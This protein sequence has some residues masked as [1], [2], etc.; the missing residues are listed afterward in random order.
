MGLKVFAMKEFLTSHIMI[1]GGL[2]LITIGII[3]G[4]TT[5]GVVLMIIGMW[6]G[7]IGLCTGFGTALKKI[8]EK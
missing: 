8:L 3:Q 2:V 7:A 5:A 4:L 1:V 6:V